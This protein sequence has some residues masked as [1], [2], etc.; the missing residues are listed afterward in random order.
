MRSYRAKYS[1]SK[2]YV[3]YQK[4]RY[5]A[6]KQGIRGFLATTFAAISIGLLTPLPDEIFVIPAMAKGFQSFMPGLAL[7]TAAAYSYVTY[8]GIGALFLILT[9]IFGVQYLRDAIREKQKHVKDLHDKA[10]RTV[11]KHLSVFL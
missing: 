3:V 1:E 6:K 8:K 10:K 5:S 9:L 7:D 2:E 4:F 11:K